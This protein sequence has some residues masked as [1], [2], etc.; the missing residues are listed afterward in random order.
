[1]QYFSYSQV[2]SYIISYSIAPRRGIRLARFH[3]VRWIL[4]F[5]LFILS[6]VGFMDRTNVSI[7]GVAIGQEY[8]LDPIRLGWI[9]SAFLLGY[10]AFQIPGGWLAVKAG[11]RR[12]LALAVLWWGIFTAL[13]ASVSPHAEHAL[14]LLFLVRLSLGVGESVIYPAANQFVSR[15]IPVAERGRAHGWIFAGVGAGSGLTPPLLTWINSTT[16]G[17]RHL[18][19]VLWWVS[20]PG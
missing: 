10:A 18:F 6:A 3:S 12:V 2:R 15:W 17:A 19:F 8:Q 5:W 13:T 16:A 4:V 9:F 14:L 7:A 11:P 20:S 1:M